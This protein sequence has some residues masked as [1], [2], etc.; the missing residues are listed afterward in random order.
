M[1]FTGYMYFLP[2][3]SCTSA[4]TIAF[5]YLYIVRLTDSFCLTKSVLMNLESLAHRGPAPILQNSAAILTTV[6]GKY[7][8][9]NLANVYLTR[10][11]RLAV[12]NLSQQT[13]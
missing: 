7:P 4:A 13:A 5:V 3:F 1:K 6:S 9:K 8:Q 12:E 2:L 11:I 10:A